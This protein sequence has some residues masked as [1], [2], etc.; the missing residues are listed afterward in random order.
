M[1]AERRDRVFERFAR[2]DAGRT[3]AGGSGLGLAIVRELTT[4]QGGTVTL[5]DAAPTGLRVEL[6]FRCADNA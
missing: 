1:P 2:S 4:Q 5:A 6:R 3:V